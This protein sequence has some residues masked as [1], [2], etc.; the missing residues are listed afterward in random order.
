[1]ADG[2]VANAEAAYRYRFWRPVTAIR[3]AATDGNPATAADPR[4]MPLQPTPP[5]PAYDSEHAVAGGAAAQAMR[6]FFGTDRVAISACSFT[7]P[8]PRTCRGAAPEMR[9]FGGF[10]EAATENAESRIYLGAQF[11]A[12]VRAGSRHGEQIADWTVDHALRLVG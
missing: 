5:T 8:E 12:S 4:W 3:L 9:Q 2:Y 11:R 10:S 6:R 1:M 7:L